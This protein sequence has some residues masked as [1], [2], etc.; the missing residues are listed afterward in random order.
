[1][2]KYISLVIA[3]FLTAGFCSC[4]EET[5]DG[6]TNF[7][8]EGESLPMEFVIDIPGMEGGA[9]KA[10]ASRSDKT[11]FEKNEVIHLFVN[12]TLREGNTESKQTAYE[13]MRYNG[14][15]WVSTE[16]TSTT[17]GVPLSW[18][19]NAVSADI[20][21]Y[22]ADH[23]TG[24]IGENA[25]SESASL[26]SIQT[27]DPLKAK[28]KGVPYGNAIHLT[29]K[30]L[31]AKLIF[32]NLGDNSDE[33]WLQ[34]KE[35]NDAFRLSR[36]SE[37]D[38]QEE[39][40]AFEFFQ[41]STNPY[42]SGAK[43]EEGNVTFYVEPGN[44]SNIKI[45]YPYNRPYLS[46]EI[47][48]LENVVANHIYTIEINEGSGQV[49]NE[50][51]DDGWDDGGDPVTPGDGLDI[52]KFLQA[53][54]DASAYTLDDGTPILAKKDDGGTILLTNVSFGNQEFI[55]QSIPNTTSFDG[56]K[57]Y[58]SDANSNIFTSIDGELT[59]LGIK[60]CE[61]TKTSPSQ[62][63][64]LGLSCV[65]HISNI[66]LL[67]LTLDVTPP[68][69]PNLC[70]VG[71]LVGNNS[72]TIDG[73]GLGGNINVDVHSESSP[74]RVDVGGLVGQSSGTIKNVSLLNTEGE[75]MISVV[76]DC[77]FAE[78]EGIVGDRYVGGV[79][80]LS[81][82][83]IE[84]CTLEVTVDAN[85]SQGVLMYTGGLA[86]MV[87]SS[88]DGKGGYVN[89]VV[90][91]GN[92]RGGLAYPTDDETIYG[93]GHS[94]TGG[95]IGYVYYVQAIRNSKSLGVVYGQSISDERFSPWKNTIYAVGGAFGQTYGAT[96][97][98]GIEA[99]SDL[100]ELPS[101]D[102]NTEGEYITGL[103]T[104]RSLR[105]WENDLATHGNT[106]HN[107]GADKIIGEEG[108][109]LNYMEETN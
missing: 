11:V 26:G 10:P 2:K 53:I 45:N 89:N 109:E 41:N 49:V 22:F 108:L 18:P 16:A 3:M 23:I 88:E 8:K 13:C 97:I 70:D 14:S 24:P 69:M 67:N 62:A 81:V 52:N 87:R 73:V 104:G 72:G 65:G 57:F 74:G 32:K 25:V 9:K 40:P 60:D 102:E 92:V 99:W 31:C 39:K 84:N 5:P 61:V 48:G 94:Y 80:G 98:S 106:V 56:N 46:L 76:C 44:Y 75:T 20:T 96:T 43:N 34:K 66:R 36:Q 78:N 6:G 101:L 35:L 79:V 85:N 68:S 27:D 71:I 50:E 95:L 7:R 38:T 82:G 91:Y 86:G 90:I 51:E 19:W 93:E 103:F 107:S 42:I 30:S 58:I 29:F 28:I 83:R 63:G 12:F 55:P 1:M 54:H 37:S 33:F 59:N 64:V 15:E 17:G 77:E 100:V 47:E 21:A 4:S 105:Y